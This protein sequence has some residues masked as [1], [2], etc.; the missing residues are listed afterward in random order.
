MF[1]FSLGRMF[2]F[3]RCGAVGT[4][5]IPPHVHFSAVRSVV[6]FVASRLGSRALSCPKPL[7]I[8]ETAGLAHVLNELEHPMPVKNH[9]GLD[10]KSECFLQ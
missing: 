6:E 9:S 3:A 5:A 2:V 7:L 1:S 10:D 8:L 4:H